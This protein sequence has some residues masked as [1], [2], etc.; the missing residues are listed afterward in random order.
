M[1]QFWEPRYYTILK[2]KDAGFLSNIWKIWLNQEN[3]A[4]ATTKQINIMGCVLE[5]SSTKIYK[6]KKNTQYLVR[7]WEMDQTNHYLASPH[8]KTI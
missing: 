5:S 8:N 1:A 2:R 6:E 7:F 4:Q 3:R